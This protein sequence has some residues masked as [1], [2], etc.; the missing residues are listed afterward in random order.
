MSLVQQCNNPDHAD[1]DVAACSH[2]LQQLP[3]KGSEVSSEESAIAS[4]SLDSLAWKNAALQC[5]I[6]AICW[7][8]DAEL[9][10]GDQA[11]KQLL[12]STMQRLC[13]DKPRQPR[14]TKVPWTACRHSCTSELTLSPSS[15]ESV[16]KR[17]TTSCTA[18]Q[19]SLLDG[20]TEHLKHQQAQ[21]T[22]LVLLS[23]AGKGARGEDNA[24]TCLIFKLGQLAP[25]SAGDLLYDWVLQQ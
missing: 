19:D 8:T 17:Q 24:V 6:N 2:V 20:A 14:S 23:A 15:D 25:Y 18:T 4:D 7:L 9:T 11:F 22:H 13:G 3:G 12:G 16:C 5:R 10:S 1:S 21:H